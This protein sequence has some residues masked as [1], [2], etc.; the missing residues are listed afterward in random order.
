MNPAPSV[1]IFTV[2]SGLGFGM[3]FWLGLG[4]AETSGM[5]GFW[6]FAMA[7]ILS[8]GGCLPQPFI[9]GNPQRFWRAFS[10]WQTSWLS[11]EAILAVAALA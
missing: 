11:R 9:L 5:I 1:I 8:G 4:Q 6:L 7:F 3:L 10:Q 2:L